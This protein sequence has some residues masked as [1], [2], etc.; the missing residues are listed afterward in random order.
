MNVSPHK[1]QSTLSQRLEGTHTHLKQSTPP[2]N[3]EEQT[4]ERAGK[5]LRLTLE[6]PLPDAHGLA[7]QLP[8]A[9]REA[10]PTPA[11]LVTAVA[12]MGGA[13]ES[14]RHRRQTPHGAQPT[15]LWKAADAV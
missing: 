7:N 10:T 14:W 2:V 1:T 3:K 6:G 12:A 5:K 13:G 8:V 15:R 4:T 9:P 11:L